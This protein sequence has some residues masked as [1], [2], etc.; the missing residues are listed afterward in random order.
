[1]NRN[2]PPIRRGFTLIELLVVISIIALLIGILLPALGS[3]R[4]SARQI[5]CAANM[6]QFGI[7]QFVYAE[8]FD[9]YAT[10]AGYNPDGSDT[11]ADWE[12]W[13]STLADE[14]F[15]IPP[16][17]FVNF[18]AMREQFSTSPYEIFVC[19]DND[20]F[21]QSGSKSY[22]GNARVMGVLN[23]GSTGY[24]PLWGGAKPRP[25]T[26]VLPTSETPLILEGWTNQRMDDWLRD[27][28]SR[29]DEFPEFDIASAA[30]RPPHAQN[31]HNILYV[32]GHVGGVQ[33]ENWEADWFDLAKIFNN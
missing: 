23:N 9:D 31:L 2:S 18:A 30:Y 1:M 29:V 12:G 6:K 4:A 33:R 25:L 8:T 7:L 32:D 17:P 21:E 14:S 11:G 16:V 19:P 10:P 24:A 3:A 28:A 20:Y 13:V 27:W 22:V 26:D 5:K 15:D